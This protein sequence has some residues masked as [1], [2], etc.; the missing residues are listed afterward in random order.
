VYGLVFRVVTSDVVSIFS[1]MVENFES[2]VYTHVTSFYT[3]VTC[4]D[5]CVKSTMFLVL[6]LFY[7]YYAYDLCNK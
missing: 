2:F 3:D 1:Q 5:V 6:S 7:V 4:S